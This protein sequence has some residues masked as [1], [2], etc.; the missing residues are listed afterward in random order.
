VGPLIE[1]S[2][3]W[4]GEVLTTFL[5]E[6]AHTGYV[7]GTGSLAAERIAKALAETGGVWSAYALYDV[8]YRQMSSRFALAART[9]F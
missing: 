7:P 6:Q 8:G 4:L 5:V 9:Y 3:G 1:A 2:P